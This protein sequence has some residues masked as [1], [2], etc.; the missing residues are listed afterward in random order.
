MLR[1]CGIARAM[2]ASRCW[3]LPAAGTARGAK[4]RNYA[5]ADRFLD[6][7]PLDP[8]DADTADAARIYRQTAA[9]GSSSL[10]G[11]RTTS[12]FLLKWQLLLLNALQV[13]YVSSGLALFLQYAG[14]RAAYASASGRIPFFVRKSVL[15][16]IADVDD[17]DVQ[18]DS[19]LFRG[20]LS[21][22]TLGCIYVGRSA[23]HG[24]GLFTSKALPRGTR[25]IAEPQRAFLD[26]VGFLRLLA[27]TKERLPDTWHYTH[28][29]GTLRELVTQAQPHHFLNHSCDANVCSGLS[30]L[31]WSAVPADGGASHS[32]SSGDMPCNVCDAELRERFRNWE[33]FSD[34]NSFFL[35]RDVAAGEEL[36][37]NYSRRID[38]LYNGD[39][40][41]SSNS[42]SHCGLQACHCGQPACRHFIYTPEK[43]L[44]L[45]NQ[46][47]AEPPWERL[48]RLLQCGFDDETVLLSLAFPSSREPVV[49]YLNNELSLDGG[50]DPVPAP[51]HVVERHLLSKRAILL[52]YRHVFRVLNETAPC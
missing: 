46:R 2:K 43:E 48:H 52:S 24:R 50:R 27:D 39:S 18:K 45:A 3:C 28:P 34:P 6:S 25:V 17:G 19:A 11:V 37:L 42:V 44:L 7:P 9:A 10:Y 20:V 15:P 4:R 16:G 14:S 47:E 36:T 29:T 8:Q 22:K 5:D 12:A 30:P 1:N 38:R 40:L 41:S 31:F 51:S 49:R 26:A 32:N 35:T 21:G 33:H 13:P 23:I